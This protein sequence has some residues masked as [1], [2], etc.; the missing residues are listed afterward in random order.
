MLE[1]FVYVRWYS[2]SNRWL[3][4]VEDSGEIHRRVRGKGS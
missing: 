2:E 4:E 1:R 3:G